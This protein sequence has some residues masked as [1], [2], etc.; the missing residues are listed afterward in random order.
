MAIL[1]STFGALASFFPSH[2]G[3]MDA[4][5]RTEQGIRII[6]KFP[7]LAAMAYKTSIGEPYVNPRLRDGYAA[8]FLRM[9]F[10]TPLEEYVPEPVV[11]EAMDAF[12]I[13]HADHEQN[14]STS[15]VRTAG[16]SQANPFACVAAGCASLWGPMHGGANE[17]VIKMLEE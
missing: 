13:L 9:M 1:L 3:I 14:A 7:T 12:L 16:S 15:T 10:E 4:N 17:A 8:S 2:S 11:V 5:S 6:A